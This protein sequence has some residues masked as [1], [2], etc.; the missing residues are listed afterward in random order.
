MLDLVSGAP[1]GAAAQEK[2]SQRASRWPPTRCC[3]APDHVLLVHQGTA[4]GRAAGAAAASEQGAAARQPEHPIRS[5][6]PPT[7]RI[8]SMVNLG[9]VA[10][11]A[12]TPGCG[13]ERAWGAAGTAHAALQRGRRG[14]PSWCRRHQRTT[15]TGKEGSG[16][17]DGAKWGSMAPG[18]PRTP[19]Q[20][21]PDLSTP[22]RGLRNP[23]VANAL[24]QWRCGL[25]K[26][27]AAPMSWAARSICIAPRM[28]LHR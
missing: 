21:T 23:I 7:H 26:S 16:P 19:A 17:T 8:S 2:A 1:K 13:C 9:M 22:Q 6:A 28:W 11:P 24:K 10:D 25:S 5:V 4:R 15:G 3:I 20:S 14:A 18:R 27:K 12:S